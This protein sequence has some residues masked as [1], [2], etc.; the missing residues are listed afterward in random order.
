M[1]YSMLKLTCFSLKMKSRLEEAYLVTRSLPYN[2]Q[3]KAGY[4]LTE[5]GLVNQQH[6]HSWD[7]IDQPIINTRLFGGEGMRDAGVRLSWLA[8]TPWYSELLVGVQNSDGDF[9]PSFRGEAHVHGEEDEHG[10]DEEE[11]HHDEEE[12]EHEEEEH[13]EEEHE[14][15]D[16]EEGVA[17]RPY[18]ETDTRS[19]DDLVWS[20]RWV[21]TFDIT[22]DTTLQLG[23][24]NLWGKNHTGGETWIYGADAKLVIDDKELGRPDWVFQGEIMKRNYQADAFFEEHDGEL[25]EVHDSEE[26]DDWGFYVQGLKAIDKKWSIGLRYEYVSGDGDSFEGEERVD[27]DSDFDRSDRIRISPLVVYQHSEFTKMRLQYNFDDSDAEGEAN[28]IWFG[29]E[30]ILGSHPAHKF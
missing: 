11:E 21:N 6:T 16:F 4:F 25:E 23:V 13:E 15:H 26:I 12:E 30:V 24:S 9:S 27:R 3:V 5:F 14:E 18:N 17:G 8:P 2:L 29:V 10:H 19:L 28:T 22:E 20:A 1:T 7:F